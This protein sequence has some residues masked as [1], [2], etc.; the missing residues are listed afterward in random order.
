MKTK[1]KQN[2]RQKK[3][4]VEKRVAYRLTTPQKLNN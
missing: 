2:K 4:L 1:Q 3:K